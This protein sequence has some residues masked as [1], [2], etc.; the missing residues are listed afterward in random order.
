MHL[1]NRIAC[2]LLSP[3]QVYEHINQCGDAMDSDEQRQ[4]V[5]NEATAAFTHNADI[6]KE[7]GASVLGQA[8][9]GTVNV[10]VGFVKSKMM[11]AYHSL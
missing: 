1:F 9:V 7:Q 4:R 8:V 10:G 6:I 5:V 2:N 11:K 3:F